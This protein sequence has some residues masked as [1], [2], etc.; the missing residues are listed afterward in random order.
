M[1]PPL[2]AHKH[3]GCDEVIE[4]LEACHRAG[5]FN[6]FIGTCNEAKRAVDNCLKEEV[7]R[8]NCAVSLHVK[9]MTNGKKKNSLLSC[10]KQ[11]KVN[12]RKREKRWKL[13]G[14]IWKNHQLLSRQNLKMLASKSLLVV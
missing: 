9:T 7:K 11:I 8:K 3:E 13:S 4:A 5:T 14:K 2:D 6:K 12:Q 10:V 1:H